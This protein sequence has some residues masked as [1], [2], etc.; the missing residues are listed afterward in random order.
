MLAHCSTNVDAVRGTLFVAAIKLQQT[1][2]Q[3][4]RLLHAH[5]RLV[6][7]RGSSSSL[8]STPASAVQSPTELG[9]SSPFNAMLFVL[10]RA[11]QLDSAL[12]LAKERV[13]GQVT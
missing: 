10:C 3:S 5:E 4:R 12:A 7:V 8:S 9:S 6:G 2:D 1:V 11:G 13:R